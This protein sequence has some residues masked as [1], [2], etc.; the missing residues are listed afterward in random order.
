MSI[1]YH[2]SFLPA[3]DRAF[4]KNGK[5]RPRPNSEQTAGIRAPLSE[6][7]YLVAGPGTGKT[8]VLTLRILKL[9]TCDQIPPGAILATTFTVKAAAELR[10]R[11]LGW[12]YPVIEALLAD[13]SLMAADRSWLESI[14][15]NQVVTGTLDSLC[16]EALSQHRAPG[17]QPPVMIDTFLSNTVLIRQGLFPSG[18]HSTDTTDGKDLDDWLLSL[19]ND[20]R[21]GWG[22][23]SKRDLLANLWDRLHQDQVDPR[24]ARR[25]CQPG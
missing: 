21:Y 3:Y 12:G 16:Q 23:G 5:S 10:S 2:K 4:V 8:T 13:T 19:R 11:I 18:L 6:P 22:L 15:L 9:I 24:L 14:D 7:T 25:V 17:M 1:D 20:A